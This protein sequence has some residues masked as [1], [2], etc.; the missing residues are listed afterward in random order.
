MTVK[1]TSLSELYI[2]FNEWKPTTVIVVWFLHTD[3][4]Y[5]I[6]C[7]DIPYLSGY[8]PVYC[9]DSNVAFI[10]DKD[11]EIVDKKYFRGVE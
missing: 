6:K 1:I 11:I 3:K 10:M 9:F 4:K 7:D 8:Y 2:K 5:T